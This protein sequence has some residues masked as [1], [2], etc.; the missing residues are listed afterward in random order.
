[1]A[2]YLG[3][4]IQTVYRKLVDLDALPA[5]KEVKPGRLPGNKIANGQWRV[6]GQVILD[7]ISPKRPKRSSTS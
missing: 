1:M 2:E 6:T 3:L 5:N 4:K 7:F